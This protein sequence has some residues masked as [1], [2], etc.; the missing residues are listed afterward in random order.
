M[1][2]KEKSDSIYETRE[3]SNDHIIHQTYWETDSV[4]P[5][6]NDPMV[7][8][9]KSTEDSGLCFSTAHIFYCHRSEPSFVPVCP[10]TL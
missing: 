7:P 9:S 6:M 1:S 10:V 2:I 8:S 4:L 5:D 3:F